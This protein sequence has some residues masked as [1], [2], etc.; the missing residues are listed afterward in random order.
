M[1]LA[2]AMADENLPR[3]IHLTV[4]STDAA[5]VKSERLAYPEKALVLGPARVIPREFPGVTVSTLDV[6]LPAAVRRGVTSVDALATQV[7]EDL[8]SDPAST[9]AALRG[10]KRYEQGIKVQAL[11]SEPLQL[12]QGAH[13]LITGGFGG[14]GLTVAEDMIQRFGAKITLIARRSLPEAATWDRYLATHDQADPISRRILALKRLHALG[15][16]VHL[17]PADV[18]NMDDM[19]AAV[20]AG[21]ARFGPVRAVVHAAG[22][23]DD[24]P[25]MVKSPA[26]VEEVFAPKLHGTLVLDRLFPDGSIDL[27]VLFSSTSTLTGPVGQIDYVA[28]NEYLNA[29]AKSRAGGKT[30]VVALNWG[31]W[32]GVGMAA[33][34]LADRTGRPDAP[35]LPI[36]A[37]ML[38]EASFD[39]SGNRM[40]TANYAMDRWVLDGHRTK[41]GQAL[42]P[43]TGYIEI[44]A[45][46][47]RAQGEQ[48]AFELR[49]LYFF[50]P[51]DVASDE[52][53]P[54]RAILQRSDEGYEF[55]LR[56][57]I[58]AKGRLGWQLHAQ[59]RAIP[60]NAAPARID[61]LAIA[62]RLPKPEQGDGL[63]SPQEEHLDFGPRWR[64]IRQRAVNAT[65]G[66]A[67]LSLP[68]AFK[69]E[70][71]EWILH[72]ALMDLATGWA[73]GLIAGYQ[74]DHLWVPVSYAR[75]RVLR[76]LPAEIISWVRNAAENRV[77]RPTAV[78]D[79]TL[80]TPDGEVCVEIEG[81][82]IRQ[83]QGGLT[84]GQPDPRELSYDDGAAASRPM[85]PAEER[86]LHSF[87]QGIRPEEGA[88]AFGRAVACGQSQIIVSSL[89]L[90]ALI[91]QTAAVE[92]ARVDGKAFERPDLDTAYV[93]PRNDVERT[94]VGFWQELLGIGQV[95]VEDSFFDLGGHSLIAVRLFA[96]VK[97][98][99][100]VDFPIS[101]LF[102]APTV[103]A[104]ARLIID[105]IGE[106]DGD[107][108][109][110]AKPSAP[111]RRF[112]HL[113][114]MHQGEGGAKRPFFLVA[115]MF[116]NVLNLRHL[117]QLLGG[118]RPFYGMQARGLLGDV[119]PH[120]T[121]PEAATDY[122]A[123]L[124][125]VQ[126]RGPYMLGGFSGGGLTAWE[127]ARQLEAAGE[128]VSLL[129]LLD[130][131]LPMRPALSR[132]DKALI[133]LAELR[134]GGVGYIAQWARNRWEWEMQ[135]RNPKTDAASE[136][137]FHNAA[138]EEAFRSALPGYVMPMRQGAAAMFRPA[139]DRKWQV[140]GGKWVSTAKEYVY[141]DND[142]TQFAPALEVIEVPGDHDSMVLEP[143]VR[144]LAAKMRVVI[145]R[146]EGAQGNVVSLA[147]ATAAE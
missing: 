61:L 55:E 76:A 105:Q 15:G 133:K 88:I 127:M 42:I 47:M 96:M 129:V 104:C 37:P 53:R 114:P 43:G 63:R 95:G 25:L 135:K 28:A 46:A 60:V 44:A 21:V 74:P 77:D 12:P 72:P 34:A 146:A 7:L 54:V 116:G 137:Q 101:I 6:N 56:S 106:V 107:A 147:L 132:V 86:L 145:A 31:I 65:E 3:P 141:P 87:S 30:K 40:F 90:P 81:F 16:E 32:T 143:N 73:M 118:D 123:E 110:A 92:A 144:V 1:F 84:F 134:A 70:A 115:G 49:D 97:K 23:V 4:V 79:I 85:S 35:R 69:S 66:L 24:G 139:L 98:T 19:R 17:A 130:T 71:G 33:E 20:E 68:D 26:E 5:Q 93:E 29:Y 83:L 13:V 62:T 136:T 140:S 82:S 126:P 59:A 38:D 131:P 128:E 103:A 9:I 14:I 121:L 48:G 112:T 119:E 45:E 125:Q 2:Q 11:P 58:K 100:R 80:A 89:D 142:L 108:P 91:K 36:S 109:A 111:A 102:E 50:R 64:V 51:L 67:R 117:A 75:I 8:L 22:V 124:R 27:M 10:E 52:T 18:C 57:G 78:F 39:A 122:I 41:A 120:R 94:L 99:Y 138:I 113:V